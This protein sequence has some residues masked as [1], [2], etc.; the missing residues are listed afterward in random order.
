MFCIMKSMVFYKN[1]FNL[2]EYP[3]F[4]FPDCVLQGSLKTFKIY[5]L[6]REIIR[7]Q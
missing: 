1:V 4:F 7:N 6:C 5:V 3:I 2:V